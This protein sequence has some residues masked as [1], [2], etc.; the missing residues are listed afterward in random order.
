MFRTLSL[1]ALGLLL[2]AGGPAAIYWGREYYKN[3]NLTAFISGSDKESKVST[4]TPS[5]KVDA[6]AEAPPIVDIGEALRFD[7]TPAWVLQRWPRVSTGMGQVQMQGYRV[8]LV[9]GTSEHDLAGSLTYY[10]N[11]RQQLQRIVFYGTTGDPGKLVAFLNARYGFA[12]RILNDPG[13]FVYE[14]P[15]PGSTPSSYLQMQS[16]DIIKHS[17]PLKKFKVSFVI[18]RPA[19]A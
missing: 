5:V 10:F 6:A 9:T 17:E 18:E 4:K 7:L 16:F 2:A 11:P 8:A 13:V 19:D 1:S 12:R 3:G 15:G 14:V